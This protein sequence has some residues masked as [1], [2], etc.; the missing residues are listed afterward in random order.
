MST[1][2]GRRSGWYR[3]VWGAGVAAVGV[4]LGVCA[5]GCVLSAPIVDRDFRGEMRAF[6]E[7]IGSYARQFEPQFI[8]IPQNGQELLTI[9]GDPHGPTASKYIAAIDG[10]GRE[11]LFYG[12]V[13]DD[14]KTSPAEREYMLGFLVACV[15]PDLAV[16]VTDYCVTEAHV[17]D[18]YQL[19]AAQGFLS[20]AADSRELDRVP[21]Y[22]VNPPNVHAGDVTE[23]AGARN[24][25]Y[26]INPAY[27]SKSEYLAALGATNHDLLIVDA[28]YD[29]SP[30]SVD[31]VAVL[32]EKE[33]GGRRLVIA[34]MSIGEAEDY[35]YYWRREWSTSPPD[36]LETENPDWEGNYTVRYWDE[37]WQRIIYGNPDSYVARILAAGFHGVYLDI[38]DAFERFE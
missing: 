17:D 32:A 25:L 11:D 6:V 7:R 30:L 15:S 35:R 38:V 26:L 18:S 34:Y 37:Q 8:V 22:P 28:F 14:V 4:L 19:N 29:G 10:V 9:D 36:W 27:P 23:L 31:D 12:Y 24:F 33:N 13:A 16:L 2:L 20:F 1:S 3:R 5:V 21:A